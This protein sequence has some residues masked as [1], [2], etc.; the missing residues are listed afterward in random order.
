[1]KRLKDKQIPIKIETNVSLFRLLE[2]LILLGII[3]FFWRLYTSEKTLLK[4]QKNLVEAAN[5]SIKTWKNKDG[6]SMAKIAVLETSNA[7]TL[8]EFESTNQT[9]NE[10]KTL[11]TANKKLLKE[12]GSASVIKSE[13][14]I[15]TSTT[16]TV[17][18]DSITG[19]PIYNSSISNDWY[20]ISSIAN[21][22]ST[23]Y[24]L[25]TFSKLN[26]TI[27]REKQG[28]FKKSKPFAIANDD[29]PY[30][31]IKDMRIYQVSL[32][33]PKRI[34]IGP[35]AGYGLSV[36]NGVVRAGWQVGLGVNYDLIKF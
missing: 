12:Q 15:D 6:K 32:P 7:K 29:N 27:G 1:M 17:V 33:K 8:L 23:S 22:D 10:L 4:E 18:N 31:N 9:I 26:L 30:T 36:S 13:T 21:K 24:K 11:V 34:G 5:D 28:L 2:R 25:S 20:S 35:Y 14:V 16:T 19:Y 3:I